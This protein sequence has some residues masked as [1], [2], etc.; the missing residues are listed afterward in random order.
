M[1]SRPE[2][3]RQVNLTWRAAEQPPRRHRAGD[4]SLRVT[5]LRWP[6]PGTASSAAWCSR[7]GA[8]TRGSAYQV[9]LAGHPVGETFTQ[10]AAFLRLVAES[11]L[12]RT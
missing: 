5:L 11:S 1:L 4:R 6:R 2:H 12:S 3:E 10:A 9:Q 8:S 7:R